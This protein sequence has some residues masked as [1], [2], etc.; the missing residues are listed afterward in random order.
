M[1]TPVGFGGQHHLFYLHKQVSCSC[2][3][4]FSPNFHVFD[5]PEDPNNLAIAVLISIDF[6]LINRNDLL[7]I[8]KIKLNV[9]YLQ[10]LIICKI[11]NTRRM[12]G[13]SQDKNDPELFIIR[14][15][16]R[17]RNKMVFHCIN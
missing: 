9:Y 11:M 13:V 10:I 2:S 15:K 5:C 1:I 17:V 12:P 16:T 3:R 4:M 8:H 14:H 6:I 7:H